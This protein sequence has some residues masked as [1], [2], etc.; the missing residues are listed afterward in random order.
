MKG[1]LK[2]MLSTV[3]GLVVFSLVVG[4]IGILALVGAVAS[5]DT[6]KEVK[7]NSVL[8]LKLS[9][10]LTERST[11][12]VMGKITGSEINSIGLDDLLNSIAIAKDNDNVKGIYLEA[13]SLAADSYAS[14]QALRN[15]LADFKKNG[16]WI[17]A[18][19]DSY[20]QGMYYVASVA[21]KVYL[22]PEGMVDWHGL[23][24][25]PYFLKD[26]LAKFGVKV[27]LAKV[28]TY[29][30]APEM[31]T[32]DKMSDANREQVSV[33]I[34]GIWQTVCDEVS[35]S[36]GISVA[37]LN[38]Y[39]DNIV[40][41]DNPK[42]LVAYKFVDKLLY[43]DEVRDEVKKTLGID[44]KDKI[45]QVGT[46]DVLNAGKSSKGDEIAVYYAYG[47][48]VNG[49]GGLT[50]GTSNLIDA[51]VVCPDLERLAEDDNVKAVVIRVNSGGGSAYASE[52][53]Y[54][55]VKKL[56]AKKPVVV[57]MGG[58]AASGGYYMSSIANWIVAEPTTLTGSIGIFGMF[59]D[60]SGL[61]TQK[62][63][64]KFDEVKTNRNAGF[65]TMAR[66][67]TPE[68]MSHLE[69]YITRGYALFKSRVA[70]GRGMSM[71][72]VE[73]V[74]EGRVWLGKDALKIKLVDQLGGLDVAVAKAA[75]LAKLKE[76][77][78]TGY[79][80]QPSFMEQLYAKTSQKSYLDGKMKEMMGEYYQP[81]MTLYNIKNTDAIQT[82][83]P[84]YLN[85]N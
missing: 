15:A 25:Q 34:K 49:G 74:A 26:V 52:Q 41:F 13:G 18:Y 40:A 19:A 17:I 62:L 9:G 82:S 1:F 20:T 80:A 67:F 31:F 43:A 63:G 38:A 57:S 66:P 48:I 16:K 8:V 79:P 39:A 60:F 69:R 7:N 3:A 70:E 75:S 71:D 14:L 10:Q 35:K 29:K 24:S 73:K 61:L 45:W 21:N 27:Q 50:N 23:A 2:S 53:L 58:M 12:N 81:F 22:N 44:Q 4:M 42:N 83:L 76:Y 47:N 77:H 65:G 85:I 32:A 55:Y 30:S 72:A 78:T 51:S 11:M 64:V 46:A 68:E 28:G 5:G 54:H 37:K 56:K 6:T 36:R 33:F 84:F 59:P